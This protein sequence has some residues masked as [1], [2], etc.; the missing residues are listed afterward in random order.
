MPVPSDRRQFLKFLGAGL[1]GA[2]IEGLGPL[3]IG[4]AAATQFHPFTRIAPSTRDELLLP[5]EFVHDVLARW[6]NRLPGT[7]DRFGYNADFT[8]FLSLPQRDEGLLVVNHEYTSLPRPGEIGVY[9]QT[10]PVVMGRP[11]RITDEMHDVGVSVGP[12]W[13]C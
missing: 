11:S 1:T 9:S 7:N 13:R 12:Y 10:F 4:S 6:G 8:T 3:A 2:C 5:D